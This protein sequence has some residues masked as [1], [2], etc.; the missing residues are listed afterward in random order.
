[1]GELEENPRA[2]GLVQAAGYVGQTFRGDVFIGRVFDDN[3]DE[4]RRTDLTLK[5]CNADAPWMALCRRQRANRSS[6]DMASLANKIGTKN[7]AH[8]TPG[9]LGDNAPTGDTEHYSWRQTSD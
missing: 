7:P 1:M 2:S 9:M 8:I 4:W 3:E 5:E 6:G